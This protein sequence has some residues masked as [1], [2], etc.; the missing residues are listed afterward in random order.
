MPKC[1]NPTFYGKCRKCEP[2]LQTRL[3]S[4]LLRMILE[5]MLYASDE[6]TFLTL[7]Y[8]PDRLPV[9]ELASKV[10]LQKWL[11][12]LRKTFN[13]PGHIR[14]V[15]A[16][17]KG[18]RATQRYHW[19]A[20]LYGVRFTSLNREILARSW[21]NGFIDWKPATAGRMSYIL[22]YVI[23]GGVFLMSRRPGIGDGMIH[24]INLQL[25]ALSKPELDKLADNRERSFLVNKFYIQQSQVTGKEVVKELPGRQFLQRANTIQSLRV[26]GFYYPL[27]DFI[28]KRLINL[29]KQHE[30]KERQK[31]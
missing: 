1:L 22:K 5:A 19:H 29:R 21:A 8:R 26:G 27:H 14:Y 20:V 3:R 28:K 13:Q 11:K 18:T 17:E 7:T 15:A 16:L 12:R 6:V 24:Y 31:C 4:W 25:S 30:Q 2:C 9:D 23:K 10:Q